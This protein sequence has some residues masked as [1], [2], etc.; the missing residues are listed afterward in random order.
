M[1]LPVLAF[2]AGAASLHLLPA[3]PPV[4]LL[5][6]GLL[7]AI[8][9]RRRMPVLA[10][11][12]CGVAWAALLL[13]AQ[14]RR[15]WPC[16]R[17][18]EA[19]A[20]EGTVAA[21]AILHPGR[22][23]FDF[24]ADAPLSLRVRL[25]WYEAS[26]VPRP[27]ERW[28]LTAR[29]RCRRG[30]ANPGAPDRELDLL[31][32]GIGATGYLLAHPAPAL[33]QQTPRGS[34]IE[35]RRA[36]VASAIAA[37]L[38]DGPS[39]AV[40]QG[41]SVG[42]RGSVPDELWDAF[43]AT[44]TAHLMAISG[45]HVTGCALFTLWLLRR[46]RRLPGLRRVPH[47]TLAESCVVLAITAGYTWLA[48]ASA[49]ALRTLAMVAIAA[50]LRLV[51]R[52]WRV[53]ETLAVAALCLVVADPLAVASAGFWLSFVATATLVVVAQAETGLAGRLVAFARAQVA[54]LAILTPV[55]AAAFGRISLIA[56]FANAMA[57]PLFS[58]LLLPA[59]LLGTAFELA[60]AGPGARV[61][62]ALAAILDPLWPALI[63]MGRLPGA[64][65]APAAQP[66]VLLT[67]AGLAAFAALC[68][69]LA[70]LRAAAAA[71]LL[72]VAA[73]GPARPAGPGWTLIV[74]DVGQ[75]LAAVVETRGHALVFD[76]G[77]RWRGGGAAAEVTL[78]PALRARGIRRVDRL[79]ISHADQDHAGGAEALLAAL[80]VAERTVCR[81][82][83]RWRWDGV[84]FRVL[85][86]PP[87]LRASDNDSSCALHVSGAGGSALLLAD[88]ES[89]AEKML[90]AERLAA[91][92]VLLPHHGS[93]SSSSPALVA[94]V[95]AGLG[96]ASAGYHNRW[97]MPDPG[98]VARWREAG[99]TVL[100]TAENGAITVR[101]GGR[102]PAVSTERGKRRW[103]R[104]GAVP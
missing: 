25:S 54:I 44:G 102:A 97:G 72:A 41:L 17:D 73:G 2:C 75:G 36:Q 49:P 48:G 35:A 21:P 69:P 68:L 51:R 91:D 84:E 16:A 70:G 50:A 38:P 89:Q 33:Q 56:P 104:P 30:F 58:V 59:V 7:M 15:D 53:Q 100:T 1:F 46:S 60:E 5:P 18:R 10:A 24:Q 20:L 9:C 63:A 94:A 99:T 57:I 4:A 95:R 43:A 92:V 45:L 29:L 64:E 42:V 77:S 80:P 37:A 11:A 103:W 39:V 22:T 61:W 55:L 6:P 28:S 87:G 86:P 34:P 12:C 32:Q 13:S 96:I 82:G 52:N 26:A 74:L 85:H 31:R 90:L 27:G 23:E 66:G 19:V 81:R 3:L 14:V 78:L 40:L 83:A 76:T 47:W 88:P 101:F 71:M 62:S 79:V 93:R 98:V 65:W 67:A 8:A